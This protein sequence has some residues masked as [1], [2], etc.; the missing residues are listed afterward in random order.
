M[1]DKKELENILKKVDLQMD[2]GSIKIQI[3]NGKPTLATIEKTIKL[4]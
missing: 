1:I 2:Y 4:D 3:R